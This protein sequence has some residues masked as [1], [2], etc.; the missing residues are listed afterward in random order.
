MET[1]NELRRQ[2][3]ECLKLARIAEGEGRA[4]LV[5]LAN[6]WTSRAEAMERRNLVVPHKARSPDTR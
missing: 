3:E 2:A 4:C 1:S 6:L 5:A